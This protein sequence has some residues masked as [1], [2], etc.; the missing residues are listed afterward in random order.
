[1]IYI[2]NIREL[3]IPGESREL[4][5]GERELARA[6]EKHLADISSLQGRT[7][8]MAERM[9]AFADDVLG[10][11]II[12]RTDFVAFINRKSFGWSKDRRA[13]HE[14]WIATAD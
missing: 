11:Q 8:Q 13:A 6:F 7:E 1:M 10:N 4:T 9:R 3:G 12:T 14:L 5:R 2:A